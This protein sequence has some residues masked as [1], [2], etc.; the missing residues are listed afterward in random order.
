MKGY[1]LSEKSADLDI[2]MTGVLKPEFYIP[3]MIFKYFN[4]LTKF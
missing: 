3:K 1:I 4:F 2:L